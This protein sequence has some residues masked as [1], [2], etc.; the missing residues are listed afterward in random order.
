MT[1]FHTD[2][3]NTLTIIQFENI[4]DLRSFRNNSQAMSVQF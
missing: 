3:V 4:L 2:T 1:V